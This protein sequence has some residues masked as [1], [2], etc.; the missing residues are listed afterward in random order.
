MLESGKK[1]IGKWLYNKLPELLLKKKAITR[2]K[3]HAREEWE[4]K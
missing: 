3:S 2:Q 1:K 4:G